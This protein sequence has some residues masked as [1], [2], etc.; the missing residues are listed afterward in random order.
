[1]NTGNNNQLWYVILRMLCNITK[2]HEIII[3]QNILDGVLGV[4]QTLSLAPAHHKTGI[5]QRGDAPVVWFVFYVTFERFQSQPLYCIGGVS[6]RYCQPL[7]TYV[8]CETRHCAPT[9]ECSQC[10]VWRVCVAL[11]SPKVTQTIRASAS[12]SATNQT[13]AGEPRLSA[14]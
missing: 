2:F 13:H 6:T 8:H 10:R 9:G 5:L 14:L 7:A 4:Q 12:Y 3:L 1:M 11:A